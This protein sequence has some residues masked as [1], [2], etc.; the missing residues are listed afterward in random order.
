[1]H[2][3]MALYRTPPDPKKFRKHYEEVHIPLIWKVPGVIR[4]N[5][6][7]DVRDMSGEPAY[8]CVFECY[9][10]DAEAMI[11]GMQTPEGQAV[12]A[13]LANYAVGEHEIISF[14]VPDD[15]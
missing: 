11:A 9:Y 1:M 13:D 4:L 8:F 10:K 2:K 14:P 6:S 12:I 7:F 3:V 5:Y 15:A